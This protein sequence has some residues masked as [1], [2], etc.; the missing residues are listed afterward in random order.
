MEFVLKSLI[1][2][3]WILIYYFFYMLFVLVSEFLKIIPIW[4]YIIIFGI[5]IILIIFDNTSA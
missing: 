4:V 1:E 2:L 5:I 3:I